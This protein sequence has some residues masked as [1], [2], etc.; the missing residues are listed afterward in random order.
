MN[1]LTRNI[2]TETSPMYELGEWADNEEALDKIGQLE[3]IEEK[4]NISSLDD[5]DKKLTMLEIIKKH[6]SL[7]YVLKNEK[8]ANMY[9]LSKEECY[10]LREIEK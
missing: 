1:R 8:C 4:H 3:D 10:L 5:L 7:N 6:K 9:H 2:L